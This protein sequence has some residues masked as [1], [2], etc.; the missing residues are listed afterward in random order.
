MYRVRGL[1]LKLLL[2]IVSGLVVLAA[3]LTGQMTVSL[4]RVRD[5]ALHNAVEWL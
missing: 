3:L 2:L 4:F 5:Q 1:G